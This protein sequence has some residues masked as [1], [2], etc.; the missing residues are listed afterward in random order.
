M[1]QLQQG[2]RGRG[3]LTRLLL[4]SHL[5]IPLLF[6]F[7]GETKKESKPRSKPKQA[8]R[9]EDAALVTGS[10]LDARVT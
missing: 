4:D 8:S 5:F 2:R 3:R 10:T 1:Q 9:D 7:Y 6:I